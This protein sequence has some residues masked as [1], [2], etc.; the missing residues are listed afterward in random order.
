MSSGMDSTSIIIVSSISTVVGLIFAPIYLSTA[1]MVY[2]KKAWH[3]H[4]RSAILFFLTVLFLRIEMNVL[5]SIFNILDVVVDEGTS[6]FFDDLTVFFEYAR[7]LWDNMVRFSI[8]SIIFERLIA[9]FKRSNYEQIKSIPWMV[10]YFLI[11]IMCSVLVICLKSSTTMNQMVYNMITCILDIPLP[12]LYYAIRWRNHK[13][14]VMSNSIL[15]TLSEKWTINENI[16]L[17][18]RSSPFLKLLILVQVVGSI[19]ITVGYKVFEKPTSHYVRYAILIFK[20]LI[21]S[22]VVLLFFNETTLSRSMYV[23]VAKLKRK[24]SNDVSSHQQQV[25]TSIK[26]DVRTRDINLRKNEQETY[27]QM[28]K[29]TW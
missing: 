3:F 8:A 19:G 6:K 11:S 27:F 23:F 16:N 9:T 25:V 17:I 21:A 24:I 10:L 29:N 13:L 4:Y 20:D 28:M 15:R 18:N 1:T 2:R 7:L 26:V 5:K 14:A 12:F 22:I